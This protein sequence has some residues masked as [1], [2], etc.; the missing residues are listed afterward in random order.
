[1]ERIC[2]RHH[3]T[4]SISNSTLPHFFPPSLPPS[5]PPSFLVIYNVTH[6]PPLRIPAIWGLVFLTVN[7]TMILSLLMEDK[8]IAFS[9]VRKAG[10]EG[11]REGGE[12][13]E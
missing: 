10:G 9:K 4:A 7:G 3:C 11:G 12:R 13:D 2:T 6:S 5:L 1:M 8:E